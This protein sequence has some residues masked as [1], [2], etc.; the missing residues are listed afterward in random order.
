MAVMKIA[1]VCPYNMFDKH[2]GVAQQVVHLA[3]EL[4]KR[5]HTTKI[6]T[7]KPFG[8][9]DAAPPDYILLGTSRTV[10]AG[11]GTAGELA[12]EFDG[13]E[14]ESVLANERFD[15]INFH[16]PWIP[17]L[18]RQI[19]QR[20]SGAHVGTFHAAMDDS[21]PAK[22]MVN[23]LSPYGRGISLKLDVI[24]AVSP[25][26]AAALNSKASEHDKVKNL[27]Y[28]PNGIDL[29]EYQTRP[30]L[31][32]KH[33]KMRTIFYVGRLEG[34]KGAKY[35]LRAYSDLAIRRDDVQLLLAGSG[36]DEKKLREF[37]AEQEIPR[38]TFLGYISDKDK[39]HYLHRADVFCSPATHGESFGVVL[40]E[41]MAAGCPVVAGDNAGYQTVMTGTGAIS[42]VNP[43]DIVD[44]ARRLEL[45]LFDDDLRKIWIKWANKHVR[46]YDYPKVV[47]QYEAAYKEA[48]AIHGK[49]PKAKS[50]FSLRR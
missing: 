43:R 29:K 4:K 8:Y 9:K 41:A 16:E 36:H 48:M 50:R 17:V 11:L 39:I 47:D 26:A 20:S 40:L 1:L 3:A 12:L 21:L 46:Q 6:I 45:M 22:S 33:P 5:G 30:N 13:D 28:I 14:I 44:F 7:P 25:V 10:R 49:R 24:T 42:L 19:I 23:V 38:V 32:L 2:G 15:V 35:L 37:V 18:A 31:A 27:R 34:R